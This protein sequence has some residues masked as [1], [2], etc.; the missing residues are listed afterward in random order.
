[1]E[2]VTY[3]LADWIAEQRHTEYQYGVWDCWTHAVQW[4]SH[5]TGANNDEYL[6]QY[7]SHEAGVK[8]YKPSIAGDF[9]TKNGYEI[10]MDQP[11]DGDIIMEQQGE[12][13][14]AWLYFNETIYTFIP[15]RRGYVKIKPGYISDYIVW[16][17]NV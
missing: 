8:Y 11:K 16:R 7:S 6:N 12:L 4:V 9:F 13:E 3:T 14:S 1:M 5:L 10:T 2:S 15:K 17:K